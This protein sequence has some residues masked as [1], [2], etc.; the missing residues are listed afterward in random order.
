MLKSRLIRAVID[1]LGIK[2]HM[3]KTA[4]TLSGGNKRKL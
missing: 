4:E 3:H 2:E 1:K